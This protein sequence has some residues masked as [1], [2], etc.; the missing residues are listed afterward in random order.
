MIPVIHDPRGCRLAEAE[1]KVEGLLRQKRKLKKRQKNKLRRK[2][3]V[4]VRK[5]KIEEN[6]RYV[7]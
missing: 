4:K 7:L 1:E 6:Y 2:K 5:S 3:K